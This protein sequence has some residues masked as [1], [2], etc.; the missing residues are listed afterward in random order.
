MRKLIYWIASFAGLFIAILWLVYITGQFVTNSY[1]S[2][3][4]YLADLAGGL[5]LTVTVMVALRKPITGGAWLF[6]EGFL[7]IICCYRLGRLSS[8]NLFNGLVPML[9]SL[10]FLFSQRG[11]IDSPAME[12]PV[13]QENSYKFKV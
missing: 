13:E 4:D 2:F 10:L 9:I 1:N 5:I 7:F 11:Y 8:P 6:I 12:I 3:W